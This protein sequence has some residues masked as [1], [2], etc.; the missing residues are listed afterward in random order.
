M[1]CMKHGLS[2]SNTVISYIHP[3]VRS[4]Q[5]IRLGN[6]QC[7]AVLQIRIK[8]GQE[9]AMLTVGAGCG[10]AHTALLLSIL[11]SNCLTFVYRILSYFS[12]FKGDA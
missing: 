12:T 6:L 5:A 7:P 9:P 8:E 4:G 1:A 2:P 11:C 10:V 3:F